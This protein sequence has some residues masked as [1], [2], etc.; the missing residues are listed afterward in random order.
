[1][2]KTE[3]LEE[4]HRRLMDVLPQFRVLTDRAVLGFSQIP[5]N[6]KDLTQEKYDHIVSCMPLEMQIKLGEAQPGIDP[7]S[8]AVVHERLRDLPELVRALCF[9]CNS[10]IVGGAA[11]YLCGQVNTVRDWDIIVP[12]HS[13]PKAGKMLP[14]GA[15][16]NTLGGVK[17]TTGGYE[18]DVWPDDLCNFFMTANSQFDLIAV[19]P[20]TKQVATCSKR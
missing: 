3:H 10:W 17:V 9:G 4:L 13:W 18:I 15:K 20:V 8:P 1:M 5:G 19:M 7:R 11:K 16:I 2:N 14:Y 6:P 12:V